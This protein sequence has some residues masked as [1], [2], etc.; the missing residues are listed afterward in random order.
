MWVIAGV[1]LGAVLL[2]SLAG[3][4]TG[5]HTHLAAGVAG[6]AG[7]GWIVAMVVEKGAATSLWVLLALDLLVV[8]SLV[9]TAWRALTGP[10]PE[11]MPHAPLE[12]SFGTAVTDLAP[13]GIVQ[14]GG[15]QWS[16]VSMNG[17]V[18][19]GGPVQVL[20]ADRVRLEVWGEEAEVDHAPVSFA[21]SPISPEALR[22]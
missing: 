16:A 21:L 3:L 15:E 5:P 14:V 19:S 18:R 6:L 8:G 4:H 7:A 1:L 20:R 22:P 10:A 12:S 2:L 9:L 11:G 17:T 13:S